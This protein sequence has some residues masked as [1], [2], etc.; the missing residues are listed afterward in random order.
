MKRSIFK[1]TSICALQVCILASTARAAV[2][3]QFKG[4]VVINKT[5]HER[6]WESNA[7][8]KLGKYLGESYSPTSPNLLDL[9]GTYKGGTMGAGFQNGVPNVLNMLLWKMIFTG[10]SQDIAALCVNPNRPEFRAEFISRVRQL[11]QWPGAGAKSDTVMNA[12]W[13]SLMSYDAPYDEYYAWK[14]FFKTSSYKNASSSK[15][16]EAMAMAILNNPHFLL[17]K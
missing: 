13:N 1:A 2:V 7:S 17:N 9:L 11:C 5:L 12:F 4:Y 14:N 6:I 15:A 10:L 16:V 8:I 3:G